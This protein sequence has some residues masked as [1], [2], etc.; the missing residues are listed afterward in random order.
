VKAD[1]LRF[2]YHPKYDVV[3]FTQR[4]DSTFK[5]GAKAFHSSGTK[6]L[7]FVKNGA[8]YK[9]INESYSNLVED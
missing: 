2:Y 1:N 7:Y 3:T 6:V 9:I 8:Q 4:Y 5:N